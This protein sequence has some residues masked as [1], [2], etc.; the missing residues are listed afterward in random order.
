MYDPLSL[1]LSLSLSD[2]MQFTVCM[3]LS[4][5]LS[6][7][8]LPQCCSREGSMQLQRSLW[9]NNGA[10]SIRHTLR[11]LIPSELYQWSG[12]VSFPDYPLQ[13]QFCGGG[14]LKQYHSRKGSSFVLLCHRLHKQAGECKTRARVILS[15]RE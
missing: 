8:S 11:A 4:E 5:S 15:T 13:I 1:S 14:S 9:K 3:T 6:S 7:E 10:C 12:V 2:H